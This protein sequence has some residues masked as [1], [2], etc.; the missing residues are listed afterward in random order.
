[1]G[2]GCGVS[3][4][5]VARRSASSRCRQGSRNGGAHRPSAHLSNRSGR[6][7][8]AFC[9]WSADEPRSAAATH[10][11]RAEEEASEKA[12]NDERRET[13]RE[14][15]RDL[16]QVGDLRNQ[17]CRHSSVTHSHTDDVHRFSAVVLG[18]GREEDG[19]DGKGEQIR[20]ERQPAH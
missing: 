13:R 2:P 14:G 4:A 12:A 3:P 19:T 18:R 11:D 17:R 16:E 10:E 6:Q 20:C 7:P 9:A 5:D 8:T 15:A 1:M